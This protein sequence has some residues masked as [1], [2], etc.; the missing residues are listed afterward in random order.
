MKRWAQLKELAHSLSRAR[1]F[2]E[3]TG[4][5]G[6][7]GFITNALVGI[8]SEISSIEASQSKP[9]AEPKTTRT[10]TTKSTTN[11]EEGTK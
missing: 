1:V 2:A 4:H 7:A 3:E 8:Q 9:Q 11:Q 6:L 5:N 10:R